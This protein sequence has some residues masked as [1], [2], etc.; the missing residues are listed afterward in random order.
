MKN[1]KKQTEYLK[2]KTSE[3]DLEPTNFQETDEEMNNDGENFQ[4]TDKEMSDDRETDGKTANIN[5]TFPLTIDSEDYRGITLD[6]ALNDK[7]HLP[8]DTYR[9][10]ME[11]VTEY[12]LSNSCG[13][14]LIKLF[15]SIKNVDKR[16]LPKTT[17]KGLIIVTFLI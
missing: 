5:L 3:L 2:I 1:V 4:E 16:L 13:D 7:M 9:E 12:Q 10:F 6:D 15:N 11:I 8:N 17:K 14:R